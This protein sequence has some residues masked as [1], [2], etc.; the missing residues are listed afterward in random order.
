MWMIKNLVLDASSSTQH[1]C[2]TKTNVPCYHGLVYHLALHP[3]LQ[4]AIHSTSVHKYYVESEQC[5][6]VVH[7]SRT[8]ERWKDEFK[9]AWEQTTDLL[10]DFPTQRVIKISHYIQE[11]VAMF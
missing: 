10:D 2:E 1:D 8:M 3:K 4:T 6:I 9:A 5:R 7:G 11:T